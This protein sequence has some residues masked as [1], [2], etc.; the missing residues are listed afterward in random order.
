MPENKKELFSDKRWNQPL[1]G[2]VI[3]HKEITEEQKR[4]V[5]AYKEQLRQKSK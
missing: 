2:R 1:G 5:E 3:G 4:K